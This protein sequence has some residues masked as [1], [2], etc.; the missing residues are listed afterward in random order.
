[1][2]IQN[3]LLVCTDKDLEFEK[4]NGEINPITHI[5]DFE[6]IMEPNMGLFII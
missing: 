4:I 3:T 6:Y 2:E 5:Q 1:M